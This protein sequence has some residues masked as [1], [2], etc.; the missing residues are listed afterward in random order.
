MDDVITLVKETVTGHDSQGNEIIQR[1]E[2][3]LFCSVY[4]VTQREFYRAATAGLRPELTVRLTEYTDYEG[5]EIAR[6]DGVYYTVIR[7]YRELGLSRSRTMSLNSIELVLARR[8][9]DDEVS[10]ESE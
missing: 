2:R 5:E 10:E 8:V 4:G 7:T 9:G 3:E 1:T 6:Y